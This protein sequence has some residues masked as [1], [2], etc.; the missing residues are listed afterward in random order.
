MLGRRRFPAAAIAAGVISM[1]V[2]LALVVPSAALAHRHRFHG[3]C[4]I[5]MQVA[6]HHITAGEPVVVFGRLRCPGGGESGQ[7][8]QLFEHPLAQPGISYVESA[9]TGTGGY[10]EL[11]QAAGAVET[12]RAF[13]VVGDGARSRSQHIYV[14]AQVTLSGPAEGSQLLT[15]KPNE[16]TFTGTVKPADVGALVVLQRQDAENG[17]SWHRIGA[18]TVTAEGTYTLP[19]VF[20]VPGDANIRTFVRSERRNVASASNVIAY[21]I[22]QAQNSALSIDASADPI[23]VGQSV[24]LTGKLA[25]AATGTPVQLLAHTRHGGHFTAVAQASTNA[26]GE[27]TLPAQSPLR[28][29]FYEVKGGGQTSAVLF[30]GVH[31]VITAQPSASSVPQG[32]PLSVTGSVTPDVAGHVVY[33]QAKSASGQFHTIEVGYVGPT[34]TYVLEHRFY[35]VGTRVLRVYIP[36]GPENEGS[37]SPVFTVQVTPAPLPSLTPEPNGNSSEPSEGQS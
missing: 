10:Y 1:A 9:T 25:G 12:S 17:Q 21:E 27:Y 31:D 23:L 13:F 30:E 28:S 18:T 4:K 14:S 6:P 2:A 29:T 22:S 8:V 32:Q 33:L 20:I 26:S 16:V 3:F 36:G 24:T 15:G 11:A 5:D 37:A 7:T 35:F 19:H 34:S